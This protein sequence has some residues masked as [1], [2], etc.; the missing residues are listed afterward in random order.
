M[1]PESLDDAMRSAMKEVATV[2]M[3][4]PLAASR[5]EMREELGRG[6]T[7]V[8][9]AA[10][11]KKLQREVAV[12]VLRE[13][14]RGD[15]EMGIRFR[16][17]A[18]MAAKLTHPNIVT[19]YDVGW[20][21]GRMI[22]VMELIR[23]RTLAEALSANDVEIRK[24][25]EILETVS[26]AVHYAHGT[27]IIHRDLKPGNLLLTPAGVPKVADFGLARKIDSETALTQ[28]GTTL[29]TP[30]YMAPEQALGQSGLLS[31]RTDVY[32]LGAILYHILTGRAP[33]QGD[34]AADVIRRVAYEDPLPP[35][36]LNPGVPR[37]LELVALRALEKDP[38]RRYPDAASFADDLRRHLDGG[39]VLA[40]PPSPARKAELWVRRH[41][42]AATAGAALVLALAGLGVKLAV[43]AARH[44]SDVEAK[45]AEV[46]AERDTEQAVWLA[47]Q[48]WNLEKSDRNSNLLALKRREAKRYNAERNTEQGK[49]A[50]ARVKEIGASLKALQVERDALFASLDT[51]APSGKHDELWRMET[52]I[53][54]LERELSEERTKVV[55]FYSSAV[56]ADPDYAPP[57]E[58]LSGYYWRAFKRAEWAGD[59]LKMA[60]AKGLL[61]LYDKPRSEECDR[62]S[63]S[64]VITSDPP[65]A[66]VEYFRY[67]Q[68]E[69]PRLVLRPM[70]APP[71]KLPAGSYLAILR[72]PGRRDT[73]FPF[74][75]TRKYPQVAATVRLL[76][77]AEIGADFVHVP[78]GKFVVGPDERR[79]VREMGDLVAG[80][81][82]VT[83]AEYAEYLAALAAAGDPEELRKRAPPDG[84]EMRDGRLMPAEPGYPDGGLRLPMVKVSYWD[85][86]KYCA[87]RA[88][89]DGL[90]WRLP[91]TRER[92][93]IARGADGRAF[94]WGPT[95]DWIW[96]NGGRSR[97]TV[98]LGALPVGS[99]PADECPYGIM[100]LAGN[101]K[102]WCSNWQDKSVRLRGVRGGGS[103]DMDWVEFRTTFV[104]G[105]P[106]REVDSDIGFR[107]VR[108]VEAAK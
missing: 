52:R 77:E 21:E 45:H 43:D 30:W 102:E 70:K 72:L 31:V 46:L 80:K 41:V 79:R 105:D 25:A 26:R 3:A 40:R 38:A 42:A 15:A 76:T 18:E 7:A 61:K 49:A 32:A 87:W 82:E 11:D 2:Q 13:E 65:G 64:V 1:K 53:A 5:F 35:N 8:V 106:E 83:R 19:I 107:L 14:S 9:Y 92:E 84:W 69:D 29:G 98:E 90:P 73:R 75:I 16:R 108:S 66:A 94:P 59:A 34:N 27:G 50:R 103:R 4:P 20:E 24:G 33:H 36:A 23:G 37:D 62:A 60:E 47:S 99:N 12:K 44:R 104:D 22:L 68:G 78:A 17:E 57:R 100:D 51:T 28:S 96:T 74:A 56:Q 67:E 10:F 39:R 81:Y 54:T 86:R 101:V 71:E 58:F 93:A 88:Q 55:H 97:P 95:F 89:R 85:A 6:G 48:L 91:T 63:G